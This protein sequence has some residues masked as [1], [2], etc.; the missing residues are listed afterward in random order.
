MRTSII[1]TKG[2]TMTLSHKQ[3]LQDIA[4]MQWDKYTDWEELAL[5]CINLAKTAL[6]VEQVE[7]DAER[8]ERLNASIAALERVIANPV[9]ILTNERD[10]VNPTFMPAVHAELAK[11]RRMVA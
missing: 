3:A 10:W 7:T 2:D 5:K 6:G 8:L 1:H 4:D 11:L 9:S